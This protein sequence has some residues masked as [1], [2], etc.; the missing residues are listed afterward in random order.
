MYHAAVE[1]TEG[2]SAARPEGRG[3][4]MPRPTPAIPLAPAALVLTATLFLTVVPPLAGEGSFP[5]PAAQV[6]E[7]ERQAG[8]LPRAEVRL[9][10]GVPTLFVNDRPHSGL[11]YMTPA[12]PEAL[13]PVRRGGDPSLFVFVYPGRVRLRPCAA[14]LGRPRSLRLLGH[15]Q[16]RGDGPRGGPR[17]VTSF[18]G[19]TS[20]LPAGG[21]ISTRTSS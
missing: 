12:D 7:L 2:G 17:G 21:T 19:S 9:R 6:G 15:G 1:S 18:R 8:P 3:S 11:S 16:P 4:A 13:S 20:T 5:G 10:N 14:V